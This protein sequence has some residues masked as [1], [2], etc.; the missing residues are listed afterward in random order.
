MSELIAVVDENKR[1]RVWASE[2]SQNSANKQWVIQEEK[3]FKYPAWK[4]S[5]SPIGF[6]LA[7]SFGNNETK[8]FKYDKK[9]NTWEQVSEISEDGQMKEQDEP[10]KQ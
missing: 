6:L 3:T 10:L 2:G 7:V 1:L 8:V 5:W 9:S 4:C